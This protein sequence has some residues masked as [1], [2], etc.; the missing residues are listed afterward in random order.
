MS[1]S[2]A[3]RQSLEALQNVTSAFSGAEE[4]QGQKDMSHAIAESLAGGRS[5]IVQA[6][7]GTGKSLG[8]LV[9]AILSG[10][11]QSSQQPRKHYKTS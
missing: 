7:T 10:K 11:R 5:I 1:G 6:G 4:R 8:Y 3:G 9:P 2:R